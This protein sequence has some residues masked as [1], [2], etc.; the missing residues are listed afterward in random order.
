MRIVITGA[1]GFV[2]QHLL[3]QLFIE[4]FNMND[5]TI[6]TRDLS[7][8][9]RVCPDGINIIQADLSD[10]DSLKKAFQGNE[11]LINL[12]AE[13]RDLNK[14]EKT[15]IIGTEN[16]IQAIE[17][18]KIK[19]VIHLSSVGVVGK[20]YSSYLLKVDE[21]TPKTPTNE[22]ENTKS[23][24]EDLLL[25]ASAVYT[26]QLTVIRPTN[27]FG[28]FHPFNA[29][30]NLITHI[31]EGKPL[32]YEQNALVNY[33]YVKDLCG[34]IV[35]DYLVQESAQNRI[36][37]LNDNC[38]LLTLYSLIAQKLNTRPKLIR[39]PSFM[40]SLALKVGIKK[41]EGISNKVVYSDSEQEKVQYIY[42]LEKG[43]TNVIDFYIKQELLKQ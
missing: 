31:A 15:N 10:V 27:V 9:M 29:L 11:L 39:I 2:G 16:L 36:H 3:E 40:V 8:K 38:S 20:G 12:A 37:I 5:V 24:S 43:L 22:Y 17:A 7:K 32:F 25:S 21:N 30:L 4:G 6:L 23:I 18:C 42:G 28:E 19:R 33:I 34:L 13:V 41:M 1:T 35:R 26:F 14:L